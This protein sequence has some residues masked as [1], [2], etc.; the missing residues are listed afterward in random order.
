MKRMMLNDEE[1]ELVVE[2]RLKKEHEKYEA[3]QA[4]IRAACEHDY[5]FDFHNYKTTYYK[6]SKCGQGHAL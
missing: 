6:C 5:Q 3:D 1:V 4:A 2:H